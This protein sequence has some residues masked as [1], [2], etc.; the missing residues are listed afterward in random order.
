MWQYGRPYRC[1]QC[2]GGETCGKEINLEALG[3]DG[4]I[5]L[6]WI[7]KTWDGAWACLSLV[8]NRDRRPAFVNSVM[9]PRI[10]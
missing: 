3:L 8:V 2:F 1:T 7:F 9:N 10:P 5:I 4:R 6:K